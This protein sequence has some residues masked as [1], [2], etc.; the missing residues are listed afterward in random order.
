MG[1]IKNLPDDSN[2]VDEQQKLPIIPVTDRVFIAD[3]E[4]RKNLLQYADLGMANANFGKMLE[5]IK[6]PEFVAYLRFYSHNCGTLTMIDPGLPAVNEVVRILARSEPITALFR[7]SALSNTQ[8]N[9]ISELSL[10]NSVSIDQ[11][12]DIYNKCYSMVILFNSIPP[13]INAESG[14][15]ILQSNIAQLLQKILLKV[16]HLLKHTS[17]KLLEETSQEINLFSYFP[18]MKEKYL[19]VTFLCLFIFIKTNSLVISI[20]IQYWLL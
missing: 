1:T 14:K 15:I 10:R 11:L 2:H 3:E 17:R 13:N 5:K 4:M 7:F 16:N 18:A 12:D 8:R 20:H 9:L 19:W 6:I